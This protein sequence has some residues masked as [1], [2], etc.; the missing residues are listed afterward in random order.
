MSPAMTT[1]PSKDPEP[2]VGRAD[3]RRYLTT[4]LTPRFRTLAFAAVGKAC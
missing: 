1:M 3:L 2:A 4:S